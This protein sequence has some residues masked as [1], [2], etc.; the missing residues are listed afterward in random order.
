MKEKLKTLEI[1][2]CFLFQDQTLSQAHY[3]L[4]EHFKNAHVKTLPLK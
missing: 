1:H 3:L 2:L 4:T